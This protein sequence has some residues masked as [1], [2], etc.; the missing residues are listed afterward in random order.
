MGHVRQGCEMLFGNYKGVALCGWHYVQ[1]GENILVLKELCA[2]DI[3]P[4]NFA[5]NAFA[6][7]KPPLVLWLKILFK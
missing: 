5:E 6:Q 2:R 1:K 3:A 4:N 7:G